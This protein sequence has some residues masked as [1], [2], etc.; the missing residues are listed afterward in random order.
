MR[1]LRG[2]PLAEVLFLLFQLSA[3]QRVLE[4]LLRAGLQLLR[5]RDPLLTDAIPGGQA[6]RRGW[7]NWAGTGA[8]A[9]QQVEFFKMASDLGFSVENTQRIMGI[10]LRE[11]LLV[12]N[13]HDNFEKAD[14]NQYELPLS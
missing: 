14:P 10:F 12:R 5:G 9:N 4:Y 3:N 1:R 13:Q 8:K 6:A 11:R 2:L 7:R